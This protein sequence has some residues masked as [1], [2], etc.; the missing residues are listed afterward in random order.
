M[1]KK[2]ISFKRRDFFEERFLY[3]RYFFQKEISFE[4]RFLCKKR[5][6]IHRIKM[7][8]PLFLYYLLIEVF[9]KNDQLL[10]TI[11]RPRFHFQNGF[12]NELSF[13][14]CSS[15]SKCAFIFKMWK[16]SNMK[17]FMSFF[18]ISLKNTIVNK[19]L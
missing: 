17:G 11:P 15:F 4:K 5:F 18:F 1:W 6:L 8:E 7:N 10:F 14:K 3:R 12:H 13:S 9:L 2:D 19:S 16:I